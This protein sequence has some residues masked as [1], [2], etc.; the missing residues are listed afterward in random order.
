MK[1][2]A[3]PKEVDDLSNSSVDWIACARHPLVLHQ[4]TLASAPSQMDNPLGPN[5]FPCSPHSSLS[6]PDDCAVN[7]RLC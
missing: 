1:I 7:L 6:G 4:L 3:D 5:L 2:M